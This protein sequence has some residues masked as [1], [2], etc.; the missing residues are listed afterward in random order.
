MKYAGGYYLMKLSDRFGSFDF[1][2]ICGTI[3][4]IAGAVWMWLIIGGLK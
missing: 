4:F 2:I 1:G 3:G